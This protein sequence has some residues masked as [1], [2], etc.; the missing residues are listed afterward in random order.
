MDNLLG[1]DIG[2]HSIKLIEIRKF[3]TDIELLAA[4]S[5][6]T[7]VRDVKSNTEED[8]IA[9]SVAIKKLVKD[10]GAK[11]TEVN[12]ALPEAQV[13]TR[14]IEMPQLSSQELSSAIRYEAEQYIPLPLDQ[15][16]LDFNILKPAGTQ[17]DSKMQVLLVAAPKVLIERYLRI[18]EQAD[19]SAVSVETEITAATRA[20]N[21]SATNVKTVMIVSLG[22]QTTD[23]AIL[24][25]GVLA[26]TRSIAA[27][28]QALSRS[29]AQG[30]DFNLN[31]AEEFKKTYGLERD[32]LE[33]KIVAAVKPIMDT[34]ISEIK[35]AIAF[36][37]EKNK[38]EPVQTVILN[39]GTARL[40]GMVVYMAESL[41][42][43]TQ[44]ANPW[45]G[46]KRAP[47]FNVLD[48]EGPT[49]SVAVGLALK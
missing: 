20:L 45:I 24:N 17:K 7:P 26:F 31:Q 18:L 23:L 32:K 5:C 40:P 9:T 25:S 13:F 3:G 2:S 4:G 22:G 1:L 41:G 33:G 27:G 34:I 21:R 11:T 43:E 44:L 30:L 14:V 8:D 48:N 16:N 38:E 19:L 29:L 6:L 39:G 36:Y 35:R 49:F 15:V 12:I 42:I 47:R 10:T 28:G 37:L 46:I